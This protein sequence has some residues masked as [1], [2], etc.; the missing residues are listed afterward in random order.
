MYEDDSALA[1]YTLVCMPNPI[2]LDSTGFQRRMRFLVLHLAI[3][4]PLATT[5]T[6]ND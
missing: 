6:M 4:D 1:R 3:L 5:A 2:S